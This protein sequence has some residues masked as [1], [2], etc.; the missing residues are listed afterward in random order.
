[1]PLTTSA[2]WPSLVAGK[3]AKAS[4]VEEKFSWL[5]GS[6]LPMESGTTFNLTFNL[7]SNGKAWKQAWV[8]GLNPTSTAAGVAIG[9]ELAGSSTCL[10]LSAMPKAVQLPI[11][12]TTERDALTAA[13]GMLVY[14]STTASIEK[15]EAGG[16]RTIGEAVG[17]TLVTASLSR[18]AGD[19]IADILNISGTQGQLNQFY[20]VTAATTGV[21]P[22]NIYLT[23]DGLTTTQA[24]LRYVNAI[25]A[26][27]WIV[28][29][30]GATGTASPT[31]SPIA[32]AF[33]E[34]C[35]VSLS[36]DNAT[37]LVAYVIYQR[38]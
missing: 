38:N 19:P 15:Y 27:N 37:S 28:Y 35:Q 14:N 29:G 13:S 6:L 16:W 22:I 23:I 8:G 1:M 4:E 17:G 5:E 33:R 25:S 10:D 30:G 7:G 3:K 2:L 9:K 32:L 20:Y 36:G 24:N 31:P 12:N 34:S 18:N 21:H 11:L 26:N